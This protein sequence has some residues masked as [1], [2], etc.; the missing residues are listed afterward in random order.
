MLS[1]GCGAGGDGGGGDDN[2][3][4]DVPAK[5][6]SG[7]IQVSYVAV[8]DG[9]IENGGDRVEADAITDG[10]GRSR[11]TTA[12]FY[13]PDAPAEETFVVIQDGNRALMYEDQPD[14]PYTVMEAVDEHPEEFDPLTI[15]FQPDTALFRQVCG[16]ARKHG[17][18]TIAGRN[19][20][21]YACS[22]DEGDPAWP[23]PDEVW[24]DEAAGVMLEYNGYKAQEVIIDPAVDAST[25][26]TT[27]PDG[28]DVHVVRATGK[29]KPWPDKKS[30]LSPEAELLKV[31]ASTKRP[32]YYLGA[33]FAGEALSYVFVYDDATGSEEMGDLSLDAGQSLAMMYGDAFSVDTEPFQP[34]NYRNAVGCSRLQDLRGVPTVKQADAVWLF[35]A[36]LVV[37]LGLSYEW[38]KAASAAAAI[39]EAGQDGPTG[40]DL[41]VPLAG[42][43]ALVDAACGAN[44][45]DHG[46]PKED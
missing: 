33:E 45:G 14:P 42:N 37:R 30:G 28:A 38:E 22:W 15:Q 44:P 23:Q 9:G 3:D 29:G 34:G 12:H 17:T 36:D 11:I 39:R 2:D 40:A 5:D 24:L 6:F 10:T 16:E 46:E 18:R 8:R 19:A 35:T 7:L 4:G 1:A 21:G 20:V 27:P 43:V 41:P 25:F 26:S 32:V 13:Y 31:A